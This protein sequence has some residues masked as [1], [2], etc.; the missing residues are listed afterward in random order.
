MKKQAAAGAAETDGQTSLRRKPRG[1]LRTLGPGLITGA[2]DDDPSG[3]ATYSQTGAQFG[4]SLGWLMIVSY[5]MMVIVQGISAGIGAVT[6]AGIAENLRRHYPPWI[7]RSAVLML[8]IANII[9]IGADL[10]AMGAALQLIV[11]GSHH[12]YALCFAILCVLLEVFISYAKYVNVLKWLTLSL[13]AY[14]GVVFAVDLPWRTALS[15]LVVPTFSL[16]ADHAMAVVAILG[17]TISPYLF[18]WQAGEETEELRRRDKKSLLQRPT[19]AP[20]ELKRIKTDTLIGM[21]VSNLV[22]LFIIFAT[23]ATLHANGITE[24][25]SSSQAAEALRPVAGEFAFLLFALGIIGTGMLA[26]PV[27]A[28]SAA[29]AVSEMFRWRAGLDQH[30]SR[31]KA[32]YGI[33][34]AATLG[35]VA[36]TFTSLDPI[37]ALYWSAVINGVLAAPLIAIMVTIGTNRRIM[38]DLKMPWWMALGGGITAIVMASVAVIFFMS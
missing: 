25:E 13:F 34:A 32:F 33:V 29:Y 26:V 38:G 23:A 4:Y 24:I 7:L 20:R 8:L 9:N 16:D 3:I 5:P 36:L 19:A 27:L 2:A 15:S 35:G 28:G 1:L 17:T 6:G 31:A 18:F 22:A 11:G 14:V 21:A 37:R 10:A 12:L 30:P